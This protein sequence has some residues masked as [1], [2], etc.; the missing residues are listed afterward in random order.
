MERVMRSTYCR[1]I[2]TLMVRQWDMV[3]LELH[4]RA[5]VKVATPGDPDSIE[6]ACAEL[7][8]R[9]SD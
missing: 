9:V 1:R 5:E 7:F 3:A 2:H 4:D 8:S 6:A